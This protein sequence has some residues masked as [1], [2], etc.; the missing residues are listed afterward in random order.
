MIETLMGGLLGGF[1][2]LAPEFLKA[3]DRRSDRWHELAM[4]DKAIEYEKLRGPNRM[5]ETGVGGIRS[6]VPVP[7]RR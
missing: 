5:A 7:S 6:G 4:Q 3:L 2:R 1:F